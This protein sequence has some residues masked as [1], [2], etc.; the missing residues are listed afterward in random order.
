MTD[1]IYAL[2]SG[3]PPAAI[4]ILRVSGPAAHTALEALAGTAP[5]ARRAALRTLRA[6]DGEI[7]DEALVLWL[8]GPATAT[9]EDCVELHCHGGR[10][11]VSAVRSA[12][13][14]LPGLREAEAG[15]FTRR[16]FAN[17][18][19][20]LAQAEALGDLLTAETELQRRVAQAGVGGALSAK[21]GGWRDRVLALSAMAEATLDF[22]DEDDVGELPARFFREREMLHEDIRDSLARPR[23]DRLRSGVRVVIAGPPNSGKSS[24]FNALVG[25]GAAIVSSLAGTTRDVLER[26]V[27]FRGI[28]LL[29]I[30]TA[31]LRDDGAEEIEAIGIERAH[32]QI[33]QADIILWLGEEGEGPPGSLEV[34]P[35][36]DVATAPRKERPDH[37]LSSRT[38]EGLARLEVDLVER[39]RHLLPKANSTAINERQA[40]LL[41]EAARALGETSEDGLLVAESLRVARSSFDSLLGNSGVEDMLDALFGRFCIGK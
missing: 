18:R 2:S 11:V 29:L 34:Q 24:L 9:G 27:A 41:E 23:A 17:G 35:L 37:V 15:E 1:T 19:I 33:A 31:G 16:A 8:P 3:S 38:G 7:L 26:P 40:A 12:L 5:P 6:R 14:E 32:A 25:D 20:D 4:A 13:G 22:G 28:P 10:A 21:V 39:A 36:C 30:D